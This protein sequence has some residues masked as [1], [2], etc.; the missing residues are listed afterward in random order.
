MDEQLYAI[1]V[2]DA[3]NADCECPVC[4]M[5]R[6]LEKAAVE[7]ALGP[8]YMEDDVRMETNRVGFCAEHVKLMYEQP[9]AYFAPLAEEYGVDYVLIST[10]ERSNYNVDSAYFE[11]MQKVWTDGQTT[12]YKVGSN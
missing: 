11:S 4:L 12:I 2:N 6:S 1:P 8:S 7:F 9:S 5:Y 3:F 10:W